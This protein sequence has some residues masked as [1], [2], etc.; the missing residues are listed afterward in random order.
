[1][2]DA[3]QAADFGSMLPDGPAAKLVRRGVLECRSEP[4]AVCELVLL[5]AGDARA[6]DAR[7]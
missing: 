3:R 7:R 4:G 2:T 1:M 5:R 6:A